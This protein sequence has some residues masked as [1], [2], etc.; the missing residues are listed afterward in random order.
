MLIPRLSLFHGERV[1]CLA[2]LVDSRRKETDDKGS[3]V[4]LRMESFDTSH[5]K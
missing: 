4:S 1:V 3:I 2:K 5:E